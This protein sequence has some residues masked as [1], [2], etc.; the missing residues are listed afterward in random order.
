MNEINMAEILI[1]NGIGI[2]LMLFLRLTRIENREKRFFDDKIFDA[3]IWITIAGCFLEYLSFVIDGRLFTGCRFLSYLLNS[4]CFIGTCSVG[5]LWCLFVD[6][7]IFHSI[8]RIQR[9]APWLALPLIVDIIMNLINL[10]GCRIVFTVSDDNTYQRGNLVF[11]VYLILFFYFFYSLF[12][13]GRSKKHGLHIQFFPVHYFVITCIIGTIVQG[14][15]YGITLG[16]ASVAI[17][18]MFV[19]IQTQ[20]LNSFVDPLSGLYNR[21]YMDCIL[22]QFKENPCLSLYGIMLDVNDFKRI[23]DLY[24][25]SFGDDAIRRIGTILSNVTPDH[26]IAIRYAGDEFIILLPADEEKK[27]IDLIKGI[28]QAAEVFNSSGKAPYTLSFAIGYSRFDN[29]SKDVVQF[30]SSMDQEMYLA[31]QKHYQQDS[32]DRRNR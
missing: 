2:C 6:F 29:I 28:H 32:C 24:G 16:W 13:A 18:F 12:L 3:M 7:R 17:A 30:L 25:H 31:K 19:Y 11:L 14:F 5:Y 8:R 27:I 23:N 21:R 22:S 15:S 10:T 20:S 26:G 1:V 9:R 4:L